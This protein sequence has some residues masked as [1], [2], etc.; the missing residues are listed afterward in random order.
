[1]TVQTDSAG[2]IPLF[3]QELAMNSQIAPDVPSFA[4]WAKARASVQ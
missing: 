2:W 3:V 4:K 1:M